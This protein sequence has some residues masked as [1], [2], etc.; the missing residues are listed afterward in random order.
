MDMLQQLTA[1]RT[2]A[3][4][5]VIFLVIIVNSSIN[6]TAFPEYFWDEGVYVGRA[7]SFLKTFQVYQ[8]PHYIDHPPFGWIVPSLFFSAIGFPDSITH[9]TSSIESQ[10]LLLILI[11]RLIDVVYL[12]LI[13]FLVYKISSKLYNKES[14]IFSLAT[15]A[16]IPALWPFREFLLDPL[17]ILFVL[18]SVFFIVSKEKKDKSHYL[19]ISG[20]LFGF[21]VLTKFTAVFFLPAI[22]FFFIW[23]KTSVI[24]QSKS[25]QNNIV[26]TIWWITPVIIL[27]AVW[28]YVLNLQH[29][30]NYLI[31]TQ[32]WQIERTSNLPYG[33]IFQILFTVCPVGFVFGVAGIVKSLKNKNWMPSLLSLPYLG[34][35]LRGGFVG[36]VHTIP[37]LPIFCIHSGKILA[38]IS[39][40]ISVRTTADSKKVAN[41]MLVSFLVSSIVITLW[42]TSFDAT[43]SQVQAMQYLINKLPK[44]SFLVTN[45][46]Y[47]WIITQYRPDIQ[48]SDFFSLNFMKKLPNQT[49]IAES[50]PPI[51]RDASLRQSQTIYEKSC[52]I[53]KFENTPKIF[54]PYMATSDKPWNVVIRH[55]DAKSTNC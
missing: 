48:V 12:V 53:E 6:L 14:S 25:Q 10:I 29:N 40:K 24:D 43:I 21:A 36:F 47:S 52:I 4:L 55:F 26:F 5:I 3:Y 22:A 11:P 54:H 30:L 7:V 28:L 8:N 23:N 49:Y 15:L 38:D 16:L 39:K 33:T 42:I 20:A 34:F 45:A 18:S 50:T 41:L 51:E 1:L 46:G 32:L 31:S 37:I 35:L 27:C 19:V 2:K 13:S 9:S 17:M 44:D